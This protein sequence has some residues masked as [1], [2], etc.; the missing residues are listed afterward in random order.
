M[1]A[2][3]LFISLGGVGYAAA[4]IGSA[5]IKNNTVASK[6]IRDRTIKAKDLNRR[7][8]S[9]LRG[10]RGPA[11]AAGPA[12]PMGAA[13]K[14]GA[15]GAPATRLFA[16]IRVDAANVAEVAYGQGVTEVEQVGVPSTTGEFDVH[17]DRDLTGC[18]VQVTPGTGRPPG[19]TIS[20]TRVSA[21][22]LVDPNVA[23][24]ISDN[25]ARVFL[26]QTVDPG[27]RVDAPFMITAFC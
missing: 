20:S 18:V 23:E 7:A 11:G 16:Y 19:S 15:P 10:R 26:E 8:V 27:G 24:G 14:D 12:G 5:Q 22:V 4:T 21:W 3:A 6:D 9:A 25:E 17:F 1:S 13:G 2:I